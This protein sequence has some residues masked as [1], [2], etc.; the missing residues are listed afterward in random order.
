MGSQ[1]AVTPRAARVTGFRRDAADSRD[2]PPRR[3]GPGVPVLSGDDVLALQRTAG[4]RAVATLVSG[5]RAAAT[6]AVQRLWAPATTSEEATFRN[7]PRTG[8]ATEV[9]PPIAA[10]AE[11]VADRAQQQVENRR[12]RQDLTWTRAARVDAEHWNAALGAGAG[13]VLDRKL[14]PDKAYPDTS[15]RV[16]VPGRPGFQTERR[17]SDQ[18]GEYTYVGP[19]PTTPAASIVRKSG[20][21]KAFTPPGALSDPSNDE[22]LFV[23]DGV[24]LQAVLVG[25][26]A[27]ILAGAEQHGHLPASSLNKPDHVRKIVT[28]PTGQQKEEGLV[29]SL[30]YSRARSFRADELLNWWRWKENVFTTITAGARDAVDSIDHWRQQLYPAAPGQVQ[31]LDIDMS[32]SDLH[33]RGLGVLF[34]R[35]QKPVGGMAAFANETNFRAVV[36]PEERAVEKALFGTQDQ[37]GDRSLAQRLNRL[38]GLNQTPQ[39]ALAT[40]RME[41]HAL[42]GSLIEFVQGESA[43]S[44]AEGAAGRQPSQAMREAMVMTYLAGISDVHQDNVVYRDGK[45]Y[46]IDAD[47]AMNSARIGLTEHP[48]FQAQSGFSKFSQGGEQAQRGEIRSGDPAAQAASQSRLM[49]ALAD[50]A[51]PVPVIDAVKKSLAGKWGRIV[52]VFTQSWADALRGFYPKSPPGNANDGPD[53]SSKWGMAKGL[54]AQVPDGMDYMQPGLR[55]ESGESPGGSNFKLHAEAVQIKSDFDGGKIP[56]YRYAFDTGVVTHNTVD[57]WHGETLAE[58]FERILARFPHQRDITDIA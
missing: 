8:K 3:V 56:Y 19:S 37:P 49:R 35:F 32:A 55:G 47:N 1:R 9:G 4:N 24:D 17:W 21:Y 7:A 11:I 53:V 40:L 29:K 57:I 5:G 52:P 22:R 10:G 14:G 20:Q 38:A 46:L 34:V 50:A 12:F 58:T 41:T 18:I 54:A 15:N 51:A 39:D 42:H 33:E 23:D 16:V 30:N 2:A 48:S 36:K 25:R 43:R 26:I 45:P 6:A 27:T 28:T 13:F 44:L 31:V